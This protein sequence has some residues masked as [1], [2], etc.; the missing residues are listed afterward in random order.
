[1]RFRT[2][3]LVLAS[4]AVLVC[5]P[6]AVVRAS[7]ITVSFSGT[8]GQENDVVLIPFTISAPSTF[9][10]LTTSYAAGGFDPV[11]S[12]FGP[13]PNQADQT[14]LALNDD[15][16]S[17]LGDLD[18]FID[19]SPFQLLP[20]LYTLVL[21]QSPNYPSGTA[22]G[23]GFTYD[24]TPLFTLDVCL[25]LGN[26]DPVPEC[27]TFVDFTGDCRST[28]YAGSYTIV[29][30]D[31]AVPEPGTILL[32]TSGV[33]VFVARRRDTREKLLSNRKALRPR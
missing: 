30:A 9:S 3:L 7:T 12:L 17:F 28:S 21:T 4:A 29:T 25:A 5:V 15:R 19:T 20:G 27:T 23:D 13:D 33:A 1:M 22:L 6:A 8:F 24:Q 26:C 31:T 2:C 18:S 10:A 32:V 11:L 14:F 16:N